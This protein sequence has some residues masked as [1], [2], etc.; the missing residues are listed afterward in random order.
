MMT[1]EQ[2]DKVM[3]DVRTFG[4]K[5]FGLSNG[6]DYSEFAK[7]L[8]ESKKFE[9]LLLS[10]AA[11]FLLQMIRV[12]NDSTQQDITDVMKS[13]GG[14]TALAQALYIGYRL[15]QEATEMRELEK[16]AK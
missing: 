11:C 13:G 8:N 16:M 6:W 7:T 4:D 3:E 15:G 12:H 5:N 10:T 9:D 1:A 2:I 14:K